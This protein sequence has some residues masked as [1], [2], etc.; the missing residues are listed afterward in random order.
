MLSTVK[1]PLTSLYLHGGGSAR[2]RHRTVALPLFGTSSTPGPHRP[3]AAI[4]V[5]RR[6][7]HRTGARTSSCLR[8]SVNYESLSS[9]IRRWSRGS[10][11]P[12]IFSLLA[13]CM[14]RAVFNLVMKQIASR[15][16]LYVLPGQ[17]PVSV[18]VLV[19]TSDF[20]VLF[21]SFLLSLMSCLVLTTVLSNL[22]QCTFTLA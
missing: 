21:S 10:A 3:H 4:F 13:H 9:V 1:Q 5:W 19:V 17:E 18:V 11:Q 6:R 15:N 20:R 8:L 16:I 12:P 22:S 2:S 7:S 14:G